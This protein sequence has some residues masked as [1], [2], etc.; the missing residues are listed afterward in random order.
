MPTKI[1][2]AHVLA[3]KKFF[4]T[5]PDEVTSFKPEEFYELNDRM[6][7]VVGSVSVWAKAEWEGTINFVNKTQVDAY[8]HKTWLVRPIGVT[9]N[10]GFDNCPGMLVDLIHCDFDK[11][12]SEKE[13]DEESSGQLTMDPANRLINKDLLQKQLDEGCIHCAGHLYMGLVHVYEYVNE[14]R[15]IICESCKWREAFVQ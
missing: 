7:Q 1:T 9:R 10:W 14:G 15:D 5:S 13:K 2:N 6:Y 12:D 3:L 4:H 11:Y 8:G